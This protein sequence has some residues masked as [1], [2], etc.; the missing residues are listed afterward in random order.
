L[1]KL[2]NNPNWIGKRQ[3]ARPLELSGIIS[4]K[5]HNCGTF[6]YQREPSP[7]AYRLIES[8]K[9]LN[10]LTPIGVKLPQTESQVRPLTSLEPEEQ[11]EA[12]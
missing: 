12:W 6:T 5:F 11:V 10:T 2:R 3:R 7:T 4:T 9:V 1:D 8:A